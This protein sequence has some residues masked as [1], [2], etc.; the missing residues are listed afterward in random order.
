MSYAVSIDPALTAMRVTVCPRGAPLP[1]ALVPTHAEGADHLRAAALVVDGEIV[2]ALDGGPR[3]DLSGAPPRACVRYDVDLS[4]C[5]RAQG[6]TDCARSGRDLFAPTS[7]WLFAPE[8][9]SLAAHYELRFALP[10][11][12]F[13]T[14]IAEGDSLEPERV[15]LDERSFAFVT[16]LA[17]VHARARAIAV[18]G[19]CID[20]VTLEGAIEASFDARARWLEA[21]STASAR[22]TGSAPFER[23]TAL[24]VPTVDVPGTPVLFGVAGRGMRPTVTLLVSAHATEAELVP[25]WT[26]VHE[27]AHFLTAYVDHEDTWLAEGLATYYEE[28]LRAREGLITEAEA[29]A[30]LESGFDRGRAE[31]TSGTLRA[32]C[33]S[34]RESH[35]YARVYW[36]GALLVLLAD[37]AYRR[38]GSSLDRAI[39][40][41]WG[42]RTEH[43][44]ASELLDWLD[45]AP[46]GPFTTLAAAA[47][48]TEDFPDVAAANEWLG[49]TWENGVI[50][51][52]DDAPGA[53]VRAQMMNGGGPLPSQPSR[54][55][56]NED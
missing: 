49:I 7:V 12:V 34:M 36:E 32:A 48:D 38:A 25:D 1:E 41:A 37:V 28:V 47:L 31:C 40:R 33:A 30:A 5:T 22:V 18:P 51:L 27:L 17:L 21:A 56:P 54:C 15:L 20:V 23:M 19:A 9:R 44:S 11:G 35:A 14:P 53:A 3:L 2:R 6:P 52:A 16:Y 50:T 55:T 42:H 45:G 13:V 4:T 26:A 29:W 43:A 8:T 46:D 39:A 10:D 24:V